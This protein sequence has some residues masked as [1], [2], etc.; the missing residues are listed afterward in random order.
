MI[1]E[2]NKINASVYD[3]KEKY[4][5]TKLKGSIPDENI[6]VV[7]KKWRISKMQTFQETIKTA[8]IKENFISTGHLYIIRLSIAFLT[9]RYDFP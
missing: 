2:I 9:Y 6:V 1:K 7:A 4:T 3:F 5:I 8:L